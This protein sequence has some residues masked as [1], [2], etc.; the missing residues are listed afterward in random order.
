MLRPLDM[1]HAI[2]TVRRTWVGENIGNILGMS[3]H[4]AAQ[5]AERILLSVTCLT[6]HNTLTPV[7]AFFDTSPL[8][9]L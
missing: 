9:C 8:S 4:E 1:R 2:A 3:D 7:S 6:D 5:L